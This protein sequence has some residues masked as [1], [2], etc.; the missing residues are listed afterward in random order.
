METAPEVTIEYEEIQHN[1][2]VIR[3]PIVKVKEEPNDA[4]TEEEPQ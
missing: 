2:Y 1:G 3:I 4:D